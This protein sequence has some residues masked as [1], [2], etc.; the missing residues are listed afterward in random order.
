MKKLF[1]TILIT[2]ALV[3]PQAQAKLVKY[4]G[5]CG[6]VKDRGITDSRLL[7]F[8]M[9]LMKAIGVKCSVTTRSL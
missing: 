8:S 4:E 7:N 1:A 3:A 2:S 5:K 6:I 9:R